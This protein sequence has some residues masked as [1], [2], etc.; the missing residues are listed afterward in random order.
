MSSW[1]SLS[2]KLTGSL[3][4]RFLLAVM[5]WVMLGIGAIWWSAISV[6]KA[7]VAQSYHEELDV[8]VR[9]LGRLTRITG[10]G[11]P[12]LTRPLS[13]PRYEEP[14]SGFYWQITSTGK[15]TLRSASLT[16]GGLDEH[17]AHSPEITHE[18]HS[19]P[20]GPAI[21][22]GFVRPRPDGKDVHFVI[23]TDQKELDRLVDSFTY[24][25]T[26][27]LVV[28]AVLLL[29]TGVAI[30]SFGLRPL[31][32]LAAAIARLRAG[33]SEALEGKYPT[34]IAPL[35]TDLNDYLKQNSEMIAR[36]RV[37]AGNLAHSL[38]TPLAVVFDEAERLAEIDQSK[39]SARILIDQ[40]QMMEQQI[41]F[42]LARARACGGARAPG[43]VCHFPELLLPI[44]N[45]MRRL[46]PDK[47]FELIGDT[48]KEITV[49]IDPV[50]LSELISILLDNAGKWAH[51]SIQVDLTPKPDGLEIKIHD[52]GDG[53]TPEQ[54]AEA[55]NIGTRFDP[56]KPG[57]GLGLA[58]AREISDAIGGDVELQSSEQGLTSII[59][60]KYI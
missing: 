28:L 53:M 51:Q 21:T 5:L 9:E 14:L 30:I 24:E 29:I 54:I 57:S 43:T 59:K 44:L 2:T 49:P 11:Q 35:V 1:S 60:I 55:F 18:L 37:Q 31:T 6:F 36:A 16:R 23:A 4:L 46:H 47:R 8:H 17:V 22:Y 50:D 56:G 32:H 7:H 42:Q 33:K 27:W 26:I 45:A 34:E 3:R 10:D 39:A 41:E 20:T 25:L 40:A 13:D 12:E 52:D 15:R 38:R 58:I 48:N 19:G